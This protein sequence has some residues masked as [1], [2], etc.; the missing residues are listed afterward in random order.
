MTKLCRVCVKRSKSYWFIYESSVTNKNIRH[1]FFVLNISQVIKY[2]ILICGSFLRKY[3]CTGPVFFPWVMRDNLLIA[4]GFDFIHL[5][6]LKTN[7]VFSKLCK[8]LLAASQSCA[9]PPHQLDSYFF[10][11]DFNVI[12]VI[13]II[14]DCAVS[15]MHNIP[16]ILRSGVWKKW[17]K[18]IDL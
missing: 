6:L 18:C 5:Q 11:A 10:P 13:R 12:E 1:K 14:K 16:C 9:Y 2:L 17:T 7:K 3:S 4:L 15:E 8:G